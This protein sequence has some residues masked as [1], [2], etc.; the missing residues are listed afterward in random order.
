MFSSVLGLQFA[1]TRNPNLVCAFL[2]CT[3]ASCTRLV[4]IREQC[5][6]GLTSST[7]RAYEGLHACE[8]KNVS[9]RAL[10]ARVFCQI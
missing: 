6:V 4:H 2:T 1:C 3:R 9:C 8:M 7:L 5:M 10:A